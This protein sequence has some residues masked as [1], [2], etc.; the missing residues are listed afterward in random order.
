MLR[1]IHVEIP[2]IRFSLYRTFVFDVWS[3][4]SQ[5]EWSFYS[6]NEDEDEDHNESEGDENDNEKDTYGDDYDESDDSDKEG[7]EDQG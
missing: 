1:A 7:H 4:S 6:K 5:D 2:P 3:N